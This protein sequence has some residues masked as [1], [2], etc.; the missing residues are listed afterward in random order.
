MVFRARHME[1]IREL[2]ES[3]PVVG[4][5]GARQV[6]K[7]TL[8]RQ[9]VDQCAREYHFFDLENPEDMARLADPM[10]AL[11]DLHGLI[12]IDEIQRMPELFPILRVLADRATQAAQFL[13]LGS[14]SPDL[15]RK[16]S[17]SL[18][19]RIFYYELT[20]FSVDEVGLEHWQTLWLRGAFPRSYLARTLNAS[21]D[22]RKGFIRTFLER[23][24]PQLGIK[25]SSTTLRQFWSM[26]AHYHG[27][28]WNASEI[29]RSFGMAHTT[30]KNYLDILTSALVIRQLHP[31][32]ENISKRQVKSSKVY[33][34]DSGLLH[35]FLGIETSRDLGG[36]PKIGASW[37][38]F[39]IEQ[40]IRQL[41]IEFSDCYF[42]ATHSGAELDLM[43]VRGATRLGFEI[44]RTCT[45]RMSA[46]MQSA[47]DS[48]KLDNLTIIHAGEHSFQVAE[49]VRALAFENMFEEIKP[50]RR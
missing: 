16:G 24:I 27:Q 18:A 17:E 13:I 8:A 7:T 37:E 34:S 5:I 3:F 23:D 10:L 6:G 46:S 2:F 40:L 26:L 30:I 47:L 39:V 32:Y 29:G 15:L 20:G 48:L 35:S 42:W 12:V 22:W 36:H 49:Q 31:W 9:V 41:D 33:F 4:I 38:G 21:V 44:K 25:I 43:V 1:K 14:A 28:V 19:G 45:P 11:K 50:L